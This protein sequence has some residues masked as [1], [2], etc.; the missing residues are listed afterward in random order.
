MSPFVC[1]SFVYRTPPPNEKQWAL[2]LNDMLEAQGLIFTCLDIERC[3]EMCLSAR[4]RSKSKLTIQGC[5]T[6]METKKNEHSLLKVS[7]KRA[8][9]LILKASNEYFNNA[10]SLTDSDMELAK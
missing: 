10:K 2:L 1:N 9:E 8:V 7:Y 4:L 3:F 6:L 5:A